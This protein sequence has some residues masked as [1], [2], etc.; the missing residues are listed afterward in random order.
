MRS[1]HC[2]ITKESLSDELYALA[3]STKSIISDQA[4]DIAFQVRPVQ[5]YSKRFTCVA[6]KSDSSLSVGGPTASLTPQL[7]DQEAKKEEAQLKVEWLEKQ[8][9]WE[10]F[11]RLTA[12]SKN[13]SR[14]LFGR[15]F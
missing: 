9:S 8:L 14:G 6:F 15:T 13:S 11:Q 7:K 4:I 3:R 10:R 1:L 12:E 2:R 5:D